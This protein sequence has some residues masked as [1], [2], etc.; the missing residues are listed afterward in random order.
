[1][2][3]LRKEIT[4]GYPSNILLFIFLFVLLSGIIL[5]VMLRKKK[6]IV[7][8]IIVITMLICI[9]IIFVISNLHEDNL[10]KEIHKIIESRGGHVLTIEKLKEQDF[11]TP[12]NYEVSNHNI[13]FKITYT[14]DSNEHVAWYRAVKTINN[15]H[16]QTPGRYNDGYGEKWI[17]E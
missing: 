15:I 16:D 9:P 4:M 8:G 7:V 17:F 5:A 6:R 3:Y 2:K 11:T 13:L 10:K 14:K 1:M 12:F